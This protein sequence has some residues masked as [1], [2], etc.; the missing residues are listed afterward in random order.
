MKEMLKSYEKTIEEI[1][2]RIKALKGELNRE[3]DIVKIHGLERRIELLIIE[4][5]ELIQVVAE[6]KCH[7]APKSVHPSLLYRAVSGG[8]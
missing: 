2:V 3:R 7:L 5:R 4:R 6:I 8:N 1:E